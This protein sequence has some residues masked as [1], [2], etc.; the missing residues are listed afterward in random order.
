LSNQQEKDQK[1]HQDRRRPLSPAE[2]PPD[3]AVEGEGDHREDRPHADRGQERL[4]E[5]PHEVREEG[6]QGAGD[7][8][9]DHCAVHGPHLVFNG[10]V[11]G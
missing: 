3:A 8:G 11:G 2:P 10:M 5:L 4:G 7:E 9:C 6:E 1:D